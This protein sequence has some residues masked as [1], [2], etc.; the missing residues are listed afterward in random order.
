MTL[1]A[2]LDRY[3][4]GTLPPLTIVDPLVLDR[5]YDRYRK[6]KRT[7]STTA[8][9]YGIPLDDAHA[10]HADVV[11]S[12]GVARAIAGRY[13]VPTDRD[14]LHALQADAYATWAR[15]F[16]EYLLRIGADRDPPS[17]VWVDPALLG[18]HR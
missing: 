13:N 18:D 16:A 14:A 2:E 1:A 7:L 8:A 6:G 17:L 11:A 4:L 5:H 3:D 10:A 12:I 9:H 15:S